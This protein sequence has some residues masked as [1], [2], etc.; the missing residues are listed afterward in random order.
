MN[1]Q[2]A[3]RVLLD[4]HETPAR[5]IAAAFSLQT[6]GDGESIALL[7][8]AMKTD[9][10]PNVRHECAFSLG[11]MASP[12]AVDP[13]IDAMLHD[14]HIFV[15]HE[16]ALALGTLGDKK[17]I[18]ALELLQQDKAPEVRESAD[19]AL[20]RFGMQVDEF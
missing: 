18:P 16:A 2:D 20:Q 7:V 3:G 6:I 8:K 11:E 15:R 5:R 9:P 13:L 10:S 12:L 1:K 4:L 14:P 17:A 19:I